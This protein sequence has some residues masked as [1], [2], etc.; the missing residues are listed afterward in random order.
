MKMKI[1]G[2]TRQRK[3]AQ[4]SGW[5]LIL[6]FCPQA[7]FN[8]VQPWEKWI[9]AYVGGLIIFNNV[10]CSGFIDIYNYQHVTT[11]HK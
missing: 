11:F 7:D 3:I 4:K 10:I 6:K 9:H 2:L 1:L 5:K 8:F